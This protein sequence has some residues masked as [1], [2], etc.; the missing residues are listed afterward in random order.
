VVEQARNSGISI[1]WREHA[2]IGIPVTLLTLAI[3]ALWLWL[4][5]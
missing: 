5:S 1:G 2:R 3:T 4:R